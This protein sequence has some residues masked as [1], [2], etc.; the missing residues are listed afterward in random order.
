MSKTFAV[1]TI[2]FAWNIRTIFLSFFSTFSKLFVFATIQCP[3]VGHERRP[4]D[5]P[6]MLCFVYTFFSCLWVTETEREGRVG[7]PQLLLERGSS[8][9]E[10]PQISEGGYCRTRAKAGGEVM[11]CLYGNSPATTVCCLYPH[12]TSI[13]I[14]DTFIVFF[15]FASSKAWALLN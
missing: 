14:I 1:V 9:R 15:F 2:I 3:F 7:S 10:L 11:K 13:N 5:R 4:Q 6:K 12:V 8:V